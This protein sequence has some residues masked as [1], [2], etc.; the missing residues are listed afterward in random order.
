M[1]PFEDVTEKPG[2]AT[3]EKEKRNGSTIAEPFRR[4]RLRASNYFSSTIRRTCASSP[5]TAARTK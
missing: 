5:G 3:E 2:D 4:W 1:D